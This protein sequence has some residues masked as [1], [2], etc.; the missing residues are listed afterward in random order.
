MGFSGQQPDTTYDTL[1]TR[2]NKMILVP[3]YDSIQEL[4]KANAA[5]DTIYNDLQIIKCKL[6]LTEDTLKPKND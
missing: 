5:A 6:G 1:Y 2:S 3:R 4:K